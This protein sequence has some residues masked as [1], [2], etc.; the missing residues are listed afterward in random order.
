MKKLSNISESVWSDIQDRSTGEA[1]R[2]ED[3]IG[4]I[5]E[6]KPIDKGGSV[7]WADM[8][9]ED[10]G[11][12]LFTFEEANE[13]V[14]RLNGWRLP[15]LDEVAELDRHKNLLWSNDD[16]F[17]FGGDREL[18]FFKRGFIYMPNKTPSIVLGPT[19]TEYY[20]GW[21]STRYDNGSHH[22]FTFDENKIIHSP[23]NNKRITEQVIEKDIDKLC[24]RLV[25]SK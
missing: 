8:D 13:I 11:L 1:F 12:H 9:F 7:L 20:Y 18:V 15:T 6:I 21:T 16:R 4:N 23:L 24:I 25:K 10:N 19:D 22:I 5:K 17:V 2:K 14:K 3:E